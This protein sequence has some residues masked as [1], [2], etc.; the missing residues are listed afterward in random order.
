MQHRLFRNIVITWLRDT[1]TLI[2]ISTYII[3][4]QNWSIW[5]HVYY[6]LYHGTIFYWWNEVSIH[7][8]KIFTELLMLITV[9]RVWY[10]TLVSHNWYAISQFTCLFFCEILCFHLEN[11]AK[12]GG[13]TYMVLGNGAILPFLNFMCISTLYNY[14]CSK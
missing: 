13:Y 14:V 11:V 12:V 8:V 1:C 2:R 7:C 5:E 6:M 3:K 9:F 10:N 4:I